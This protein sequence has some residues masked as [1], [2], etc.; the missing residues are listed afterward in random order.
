M[1]TKI[2]QECIQK[3]SSKANEQQ[4]IYTLWASCFF[5]VLLIS[6][7]HKLCRG[8]SIGYSY[9]VSVVVSEKKI[10]ALGY[11]TSEAPT[12]ATT[13]ATRKRCTSILNRIW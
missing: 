9:Q 3:S 5:C 4:I 2:L 12:N 10:E 7:K 8:P 6:I 1:H 11:S 13:L